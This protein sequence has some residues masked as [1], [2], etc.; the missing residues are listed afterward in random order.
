[1][2]NNALSGYK[3]DTLILSA[4]KDRLVFNQ[5]EILLESLIMNAIYPVLKSDHSISM[6]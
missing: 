5:R 4:I 3:K 2:D 6:Q 1:L